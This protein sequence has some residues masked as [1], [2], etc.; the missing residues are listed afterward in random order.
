VDIHVVE[1]SGIRLET[2]ELEK[3]RSLIGEIAEMLTCLG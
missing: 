3:E 2:L 1:R